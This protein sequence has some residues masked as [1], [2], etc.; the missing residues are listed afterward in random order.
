MDKK[1]YILI[2]VLAALLSIVITRGCFRGKG[3]VVASNISKRYLVCANCGA[4]YRISAGYLQDLGAEDVDYTE[5][6]I[7]VRCRECGKMTASP[8]MVTE[9]DGREVSVSG[10]PYNRNKKIEK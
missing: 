2:A 4:Q 9:M 8:G 10:A 3:E 6:S 1:T 7:L 5:T